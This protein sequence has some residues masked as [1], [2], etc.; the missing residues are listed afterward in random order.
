MNH[1]TS[2]KKTA[3]HLEKKS[4]T[5][6]FSINSIINKCALYDIVDISVLVFN[7]QKPTTVVKDG[8]PL[9]MKKGM[10]KGSTNKMPIVIFESLI[11]QISYGSCYAMTTNK[12]VQRYLDEQTPK[13]TLTSEVC[14]DKDIEVTKN[15]DDIYIFPSQTNIFA[16]FV[17]LDLKTLAQTYLYSICNVSVSIE[18][19]LTW[20]N[21]CNNVSAQSTCKSKAYLGLSFNNREK[22]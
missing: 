3:I 20:C 22:V 19:G 12:Q 9:Q 21:N 16:K 2:A 17:A 8:K 7:L 1:F 18:N 5:K 6:K 14:S 4:I 13:I 15:D 11:E 10:I